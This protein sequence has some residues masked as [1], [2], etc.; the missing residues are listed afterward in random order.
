LTLA[1]ARPERTPGAAASYKR[2]WVRSRAF[3][4]SSSSWCQHCKLEETLIFTNPQQTNDKHSTKKT[5]SLQEDHSKDLLA[6][7]VQE[8]S[9]KERKTE[10]KLV[11]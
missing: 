4:S 11:S 6:W 9:Q 10:T 5:H 3:S 8:D 7:S 2:T 1:L